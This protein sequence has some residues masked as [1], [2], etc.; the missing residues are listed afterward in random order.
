MSRPQ[1]YLRCTQLGLFGTTVN[2]VSPF[3][4]QIGQ[5]FHFFG[6]N[7]VFE[8][9]DYDYMKIQEEID[10]LTHRYGGKNP[11]I[12]NVVY[13]NGA[14]DTHFDF[15]ITDV[16]VRANSTVINIPGKIIS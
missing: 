12:S 11:G 13:T 3:G 16:E 9:T 15:G 6:C 2:A 4:T 5:D 14:L 8:D 7:L 1:I 10:V